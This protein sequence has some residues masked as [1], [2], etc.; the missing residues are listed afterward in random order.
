MIGSETLDIY[1]DAWNEDDQ[2]AR[3]ALLRK[4]LADDAVYCDPT[5][6]VA[7]PA[8]LAEHIGQTR[9]AFGR[10]RI[11]RTSGYEEHHG[12]GRF[13][14]RMESD[15]GELIVEGFDVVRIAAD[16]RLQTVIGFFGPFP[17]G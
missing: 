2:E 1:G 13:S 6:E 16:G 9:R 15:D 17:E 7:G 10:F 3:E 8:A 14:W 12:Y 5:A 4:S 11:E